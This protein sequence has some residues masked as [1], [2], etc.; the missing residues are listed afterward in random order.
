MR[1]SVEITNVATGETRA[2][3]DFDE[4]EDEF[5][6]W[7]WTE[8][9]FGCDCNRELFFEGRTAAE[10]SAALCGHARYKAR[11]VL[12]SGIKIEFD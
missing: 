1:Y 9:N 4:W 10:N 8:G 12:E 6:L 7:L 2:V 5:T 3:P 11:A